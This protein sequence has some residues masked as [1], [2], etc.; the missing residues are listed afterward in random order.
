MVSVN[1]T[2]VSL[3]LSAHDWAQAVDDGHQVD[4]A[5]F[6]FSKAFDCV[7]HER[8]KAK[9]HIYGIRGKLLNRIINILT[10][11]KQRVVINGTSSDWDKVVPQ[12]TV[13][14]PLLLLLYINDMADD[15]QSEIRLF[16]D[17]CILYKVVN[18]TADCVK[19]QDDIDQLDR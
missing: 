6:D 4:I 15:L 7:P 16:A 3:I 5:I 8:L 2:L 13:L 9:L 19:L 12:G 17:D 14:G 18:N 1:I 11:R 10:K